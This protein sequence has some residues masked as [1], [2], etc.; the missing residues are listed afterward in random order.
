MAL[1]QPLDREQGILLG[2]TQNQSRD[3]MNNPHNNQF[4]RSG[5]FCTAYF[6]PPVGSVLV[7]GVFSP[8]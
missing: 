6:N 4:A 7:T 3:D 5:G 1:L 2:T 8:G